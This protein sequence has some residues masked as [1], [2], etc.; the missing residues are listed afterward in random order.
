[1]NPTIYKA[2]QIQAKMYYSVDKPYTSAT[3][4]IDLI[5]LSGERLLIK[6]FK[7]NKHEKTISKHRNLIAFIRK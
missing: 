1:M 5:Q 3:R 4:K 2:K 6:N 7:K